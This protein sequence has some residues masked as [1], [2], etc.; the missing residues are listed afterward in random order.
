M[1]G[2]TLAQ[3]TDAIK[4]S[5]D[6]FSMSRSFE[7]FRFDISKGQTY[8][9]VRCDDNSWLTL[10]M[11]MGG[12]KTPA[13]SC[14]AS[15]LLRLNSVIPGPAKFYKKDDRSFGIRAD[16]VV[17]SEDGEARFFSCIESTVNSLASAYALFQRSNGNG[18][19]PAERRSAPPEKMRTLCEE[20]G[21]DFIEHPSACTIRLNVP[22]RIFHATVETCPKGDLLL[23]V[24]LT[25]ITDWGYGSRLSLSNML[26][27]FSRK[28]RM[29]RPSSLTTAE[30]SQ[31][32][33]FEVCL[34]QDFSAPELDLAHSSLSLACQLVGDEAVVLSSERLARAY[35]ALTCCPFRG[36]GKKHQKK[37][38][39][40]HESDFNSG[41]IR[42]E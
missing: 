10:D 28:V 29:V 31:V 39:E 41:N 9:D 26:L 17:S 34:G 21:L 18:T 19:K 5:V 3:L 1:S 33:L 12:K 42:H 35:L 22:E 36:N 2:K 24:L 11:S 30:G 13:M 16:V 27:T 4:N 23:S 32:V 15:D 14:Q 7:D 40:N 8:V 38:G 20:A 25:E 6:P 37:G